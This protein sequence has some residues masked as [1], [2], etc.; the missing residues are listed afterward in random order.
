MAAGKHREFRGHRLGG[1][2]LRA[3][4]ER[5]QHGAGADGGVEAF[6]EAALAGE[7]QRGEAGNPGAGEIGRGVGRMK[8]RL[9]GV[10]RGDHGARGLLHAVRIQKITTQVDDDVA[11]PRHAQAAGVRDRGDDG[12]FEV[13]QVGGGAECGDIPG[14]EDDGHAFLRFGDGDLGAVQAVV[15]EEDGVEVDFE[16]GRE[17]AD[18]DGHA[19]GAEVVAALDK[20]RDFRIPEEA[21]VFALHWRV[22]L[23]HF[24]GILERGLGVFLGGA[25]G[26]AHAVAAGTAAD[27]DDDVAGSGL[28][29]PHVGARAG[30]D[31][32]ADL[33]ARGD[34]VGVVGLRR[35]GRWRGRSGCRRRSSRAPRRA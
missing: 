5:M 12:A 10:G 9:R 21:L 33:H 16:R 25:G 17:F 35:R 19:A 20:A 28:F 34:E 26:A 15:L 14:L 31:D 32:R 1:R 24:G 23:L 30:G 13:F 29:A 2:G 11:A 8:G 4:A 27:E 7:R 18:G 6:D 22:A 3:T